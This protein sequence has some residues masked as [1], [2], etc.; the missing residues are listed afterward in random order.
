MKLMRRTKLLILLLA[1]LVVLGIFARIYR[2][3]SVPVG[4]YWDEVAILADAVSLSQTG[5]DI[6]GNSWFQTLFLSYGDYKLPLYIWLSSLVVWITGASASAV[7]AVS[8]LAGLI[9]IFASGYLATQLIPVRNKSNR[10][11]LFLSVA[12]TVALS[13]WSVLFSRT[14]FEAHLGMVLLL[15]SVTSLVTWKS[16]YGAFG[17]A[18]LGAAAVY[19]YFSVRFVWPV[20]FISSVLLLYP[21]ELKST[22]KKPSVVLKRVLSCIVLPGIIFSLLLLPLYLSDMYAPSQSLRL[23][24]ASVISIEPYALESNLYRQIAGNTLQDRVLFHRY[25]FQL[26]DFAAQLATHV[27]PQ[28]MFL[29]GDSN[30]RHSTGS[31]GLFLIPFMV[32]FVLGFIHLYKKY[33]K[34]ALLLTI[35]WLVALVPASV[36]REVPHA[37]RSINAL[38]ALAISIGYGWYWVLRTLKERLLAQLVFILLI[39]LCFIQFMAH[40]FWVYPYESAQDWQAGYHELAMAIKS[41]QKQSNAERTI[42]VPFDDR[43]FLHLIATETVDI[44]TTQ[45]SLAEVERPSQLGSVFFEVPTT[46]S[47]TEYEK[48]VIIVGEKSVIDDMLSSSENITTR[49]DVR[50]PYGDTTYSI[51]IYD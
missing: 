34:V 22:L 13:P 14:G 1:G 44:P 6:H 16:K 12:A 47:L 29:Y 39:L 33:P 45:Q 20:V 18:I 30:L 27:D 23:S 35:W 19:S 11:L 32:F 51:V 28:F 36:P 9:S 46:S 10:S 31:H 50:S 4:L 37:L 25:F 48:P 41:A 15:L 2:F 17:A 43:F 38:P 8:L 24:T 49:E 40:Y 3:G 21:L 42:V 5:N 7:R 26:H